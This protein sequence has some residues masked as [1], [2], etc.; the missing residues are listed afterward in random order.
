[1]AANLA[2]FVDS[3]PWGKTVHYETTQSNVE[4][5]AHWARPEPCTWMALLSAPA[6]QGLPAEEGLASAS[7]A[8]ESGPAWAYLA[9][10]GRP[11]PLWMM[12]TRTPA[13]GQRRRIQQG[14]LVYEGCGFL[15]KPGAYEFV[16]QFDPERGG[17]MANTLW[18][19][20]HGSSA[21]ARQG[22]GR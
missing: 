15:G 4:G 22:E 12:A 17:L 21:R 16:A 1:M 20:L 13:P 10:V 18:N 6:G 7:A 11:A 2:G 14:A 19:D 3:S 9:G 5:V 8:T